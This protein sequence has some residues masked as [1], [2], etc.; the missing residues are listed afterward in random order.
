MFGGEALG[1]KHQTHL[2]L[3]DGTPLARVWHTIVDR[4]GIKVDELQDSKGP[5]DELIG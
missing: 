2:Q 3:P 1:I 4:I 5:I